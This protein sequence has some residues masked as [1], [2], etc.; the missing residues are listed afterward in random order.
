VAKGDVLFKNGAV[1]LA[2]T[3]LFKSDVLVKD[4]KI[5]EV[6]PDVRRPREAELIDATGHHIAPGFIDVHVHGAVGQMFELADADGYRKIASTLAKFGTTGFLATLSAMPHE[7]TVAALETARE[8]SRNSGGAKMLGIHMEG[9]YL[10]PEMAGAQIIGAMRLPST[11]ELEEYF[12]VAGGLIRIMTLAPE[13]QGALELI[14]ALRSRG[15]V[16]AVGHSNATFAQIRAAVG[17][18]LT[19]SSHTFNAMRGLHHREP[20]VVGAALVMDLLTAELICDG[21]HVAPAVVSVVM[22]CK[23]RDKVVLISDAVAALGL[24]EGDH[25]FLGIPVSVKDGAV[26]LKNSDNLA[27][28]V[29]TLDR[30]VKNVFEWFGSNPSEK[31]SLRETFMMASLNPARAIGID[32]AKGQIAVG[33]DAEI[34]LM[35]EGFGIALTMVEGRIVYRRE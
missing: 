16:A 3:V 28:S 11:E 21:H 20:G 30:A 32:S 1:V 8:F 24:P 29:L 14:S 6:G 22:R 34:I 26:R 2:D 13:L 18:G 10:S 35:D 15:I 19:H 23:P 9:P 12:G 33:K 4:G 17:A 25:D 27:G 5:A 7:Q 31:I